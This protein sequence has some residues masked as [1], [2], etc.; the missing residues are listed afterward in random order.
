MPRMPEAGPLSEDLAAFLVSGLSISVAT[1]DA[2]LAPTGLRAWAAAV[3]GD[4]AHVDVYFHAKNAGAVLGNLEANGR[5]AVLFVHP[6]TS[7]ACQLKG[8]FVGSRKA[9]PSER[10]EVE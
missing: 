6:S 7:R 10:K 8:T 1:R 2:D 3:D 5:I 4:R 9:L